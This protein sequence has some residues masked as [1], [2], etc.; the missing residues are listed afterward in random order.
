MTKEIIKKCDNPN[1]P[2][3]VY[4]KKK[5]FPT[6]FDNIHYGR[7][8]FCSKDCKEKWV[9]LVQWNKIQL[10]RLESPLKLGNPRKVSVK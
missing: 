10:V 8:F 7:Q 3:N 1:C 9:L 2:K 4:K 6:I 5:L